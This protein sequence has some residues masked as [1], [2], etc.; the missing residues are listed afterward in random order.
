MRIP[1]Q[2]NLAVLLLSE[3]ALA[4]RQYIPLSEI[5]QKHSVSRLFLK[6]IARFLKSAGFLTSQE[7]I[8]GGYVL[9]K[10][11]KTITLWDVYRS[12]QHSKLPIQ[13]ESLYRSCPLN[14][15]CLPQIIHHTMTDTIET[16]MKTITLHSIL[17][18]VRI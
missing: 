7:G 16:S 18:R 3:L 6:K 1:F 15:N 8:K 14:S 17:E 5:S 9:S 4:P 13:P 11:P 2:E 10:D 12:L